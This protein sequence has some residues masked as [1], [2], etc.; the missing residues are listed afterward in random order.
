MGELVNRHNSILKRLEN[1]SV[2]LSAVSDYRKVYEGCLAIEMS[3]SNGNL[4]DAVDKMVSN[5]QSLQALQQQD[6]HNDQLISLLYR[7]TN[8]KFARIQTILSQQLHK[9]IHVS[10]S[11]LLI[12]NESILISVLQMLH[13]LDLVD[14]V[15]KPLFMELVSF[16]KQN[17]VS[18]AELVVSEHELKVLTNQSTSGY[19]NTLTILTFLLDHFFSLDSSLVEAF[20]EF[21]YEPLEAE[22]LQQIQK[23]LPTTILEITQVRES[24]RPVIIFDMNDK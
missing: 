24:L 16:T 5:R 3:L 9:C 10:P 15:L 14:V 1:A 17:L 4:Q 21:I 6:R 2:L 19:S 12:Q 18:P 20:Q 13:Q 23:S 11:S 8:R 22:I 7:A